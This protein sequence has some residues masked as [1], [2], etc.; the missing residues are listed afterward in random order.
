VTDLVEYALMRGIRV[1]PEVELP[2]PRHVLGPT[3]AR[4]DPRTR[5][6]RASFPVMLS[7]D[8]GGRNGSGAA[9]SRP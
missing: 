8:A 5:V 3:R 9:E 7:D 4:Q 2:Q 6:L 1:M